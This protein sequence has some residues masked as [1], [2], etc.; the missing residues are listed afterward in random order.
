[1]VMLSVVMEGFTE[2]V[3]FE[4]TLGS[5]GSWKRTGRKNPA[6]RR[7]EGPGCGSVLGIVR[8]LRG[9]TVA[10]AEAEKAE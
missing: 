10:R 3:T 2:E 5:W 4:Q 7:E 8:S 1:M 6:G 9:L